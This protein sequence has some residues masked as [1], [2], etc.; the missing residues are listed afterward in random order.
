MMGERG[1]RYIKIEELDKVVQ[2]ITDKV[3]EKYEL[4]ITEIWIEKVTAT[5]ANKI[6]DQISKSLDLKLS[7]HLLSVTDRMNNAN[8]IVAGLG[9][10]L[11]DRETENVALKVENVELR[12]SIDELKTRLEQL[13]QSNTLFTS[14][15]IPSPEE[16]EALNERLEDPRLPRKNQGRTPKTF[17]SR[18]SRQVL[19]PPKIMPGTA[20]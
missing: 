15:S 19:I 3:F 13:D 7:E 17:S 12:S 9:K 10:R 11:D 16:I 8:E 5:V 2:Q 4:K 1:N 14:H 20:C 6:S 18:L